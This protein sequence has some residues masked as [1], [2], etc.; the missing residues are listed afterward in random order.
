MSE[1][2]DNT[3]KLLDILDKSSLIKNLTKYKTRL[4]NNNEIL[5]KIKDTKKE[6]NTDKLILKRK[7]LY[8]NNDYKMYMKY[9]NEL[10]LIVLK[11]NK[12]YSEYI[13]LKEHSC[14][15]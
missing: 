14:G 12:K 13:N 7:E 9:Y 3:Y 8:S 15:I 5:N 11:I 1:I 2:I 10:S 6:K 4:L